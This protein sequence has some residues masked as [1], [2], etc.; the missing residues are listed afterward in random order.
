[1]RRLI[2]TTDVDVMHNPPKKCCCKV[3]RMHLNRT[4]DSHNFYECY[5]NVIA[6]MG[7]GRYGLIIHD[8]SPA[9]SVYSITYCPWCGS[10]LRQSKNFKH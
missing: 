3:M 9:H 5:D 4:C 6:Y 7:S 10:S 1:M 8:S 2:S